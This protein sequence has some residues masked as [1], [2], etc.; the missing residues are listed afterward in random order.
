MVSNISQFSCANLDSM[1]KEKFEVYLETM[2]L[3][4]KNILL[5]EFKFK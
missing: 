1:K 4:E 5:F 2:N 3:F